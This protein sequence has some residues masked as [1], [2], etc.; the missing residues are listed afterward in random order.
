[1]NVR[2][3]RTLAPLLLGAAILCGVSRSAAAQAPVSFE[4]TV[5]DLQSRDARVR[6]RAIEL[7]RAAA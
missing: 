3:F 1:M 7:L 4:S 5:A 6:A 2:T